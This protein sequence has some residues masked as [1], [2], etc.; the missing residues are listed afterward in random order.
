MKILI[1]TGIYPPDIGGMATIMRELALRLPQWGVE[2]TIVTYAEADSRYQDVGV[3]IL[4]INR[5]RG[6]LSRY[7]SYF[8]SVFSAGK[9]ADVIYGQDLISSGF[10]S[11]IAAL[12]RGQH[13]ILRLGG[14]FL[15]EKHARAGGKVPL[16]HFYDKPKSFVEKIYLIVYRFVLRVAEHIIFNSQFQADLYNKV[17]LHSQKKISVI[18]N[19]FLNT[20]KPRELPTSDAPV[21]YAGRFGHH[22]NLARLI[23]VYAKLDSTRPLLLIG[24]GKEQP[25][26]EQLIKSLRAEGKIILSHTVSHE[27]LLRIFQEAYLVVIPTLSEINPNV[28]IE[29]LSC[30][31]P[32][33]ITKY[34]GFAPALRDKL[35]E[36]DPLNDDEMKLVLEQTLD[37]KNYQDYV[38]RL[39]QVDYRWSWEDVEKEHLTVFKKIYEDT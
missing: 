16:Q 26:Y 39:K 18:P 34:N 38:K 8:W 32:I 9:S 36:F 10:P 21:V 5:N 15:W 28:G 1:A 35:V 12:L 29:A 24:E 30:G 23:K 7:W 33:I 2:V 14:D 31:T 6:L 3:P 27:E 25:E 11:A 19:P 20:F 4:A 17:F 13:F 37:I 22:K